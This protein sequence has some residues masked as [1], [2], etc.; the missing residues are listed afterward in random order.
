[1]GRLD[2]SEYVSPTNTTVEKIPHRW[3]PARETKP[4]ARQH[5]LAYTTNVRKYVAAR[6]GF[7]FLQQLSPADVNAVYASL[8]DAGARGKPMSPSSRPGSRARTC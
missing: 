5:P 3:L 7:K 6:L 1:M 2:R 4:S 8:L